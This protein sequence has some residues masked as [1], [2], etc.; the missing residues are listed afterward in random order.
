M[1][2]T[3]ITQGVVAAAGLVLNPN[4]SL[5]CKESVPSVIKLNGEEYARKD[6]LVKGSNSRKK[7]ANVLSIPLMSDNNERS[8][9]LGRNMITYRRTRLQSDIIEAC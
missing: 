1:A 5:Y 2:Y 7:T 3:V 6:D 9:S 8:F 4:H